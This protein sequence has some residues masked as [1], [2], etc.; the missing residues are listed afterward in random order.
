VSLDDYIKSMKEGQ[1]NIYFVTGQTKDAAMNN[2]FMEVFKESDVPILIVT[3]NVDEIL[4]QQ[5]GLYKNFKFQSIETSY[6]EISKDLGDKAKNQNSNAPSIPD[7]DVT[8]FS[9]WL[10]NEL[11]P[12]G[13]KVT[14]SRRLKGVPAV[15]FGQVSASMRMVM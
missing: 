10:K 4:F 5:I 11:K 2:P 15:L 8:S 9:L 6:E 14:V 1:K 3:N 13:S 12:H 7:D